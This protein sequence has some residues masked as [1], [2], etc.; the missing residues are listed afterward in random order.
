LIVVAYGTNE[1]GHLSW[2][3]ETYREMFAKIIAR[4]RDA[5]PAATI[6][7]AG[8]PD[9]AMRIRKKGWVTMDGVDR[10]IEAQRQ[11][12]A[13]LGC[14]FWDQRASMGGKGAMQ[15]WVRAG[16]AQGDYVHLTG[17]GYHAMGD[18]LFRDVMEHYN[19]FVKAREA[20]A[21]NSGAAK[22]VSPIL[23]APR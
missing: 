3:P 9:R 10:I 18:A 15:Q 13:G 21:E 7:V 23:A 20:L 11:V 2:T 16:M 19:T 14:V 22:A 17:P 5:A 12:C 4:L 1:A 8:P 6:L